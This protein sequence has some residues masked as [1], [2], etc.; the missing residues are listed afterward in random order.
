VVGPLDQR[1]QRRVECRLKDRGAVEDQAEEEQAGL[2][3]QRQEGLCGAAGIH[4]IQEGVREQ[5]VV[6]AGAGRIPGE[7]EGIRGGPLDL[8]A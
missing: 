6:G 2:A 8:K 7:I 1:I 3:Q 4:Q 5:Q